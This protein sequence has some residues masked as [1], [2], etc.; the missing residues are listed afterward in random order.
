M[1]IAEPT[2]ARDHG[3]HLF[4][5]LMAFLLALLIMAAAV[6]VLWRKSPRRRA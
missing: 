3:S 2:A 5:W 6:I 4:K 1:P